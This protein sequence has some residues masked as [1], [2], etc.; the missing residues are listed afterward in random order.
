MAMAVILLEQDYKLTFW[1]IDKKVVDGISGAAANPRNFPE[2]IM[3]KHTRALPEIGEAVFGADLVVFSVASP[4]LRQTALSARLALSRNVAIVTVAKGLEQNSLKTMVEV[5]EESL[6]G[7]YHDHIAAFSGP[8]LAAEVV[9]KKPLAAVIASRRD[10]SY[11]QRAIRAFS[12]NWCKIY[13]TRDVLGVE[14]AGVAKHL[15]AMVSGIAQGLGW[16]ENSRA[17]IL[18]EAFRDAGRLVWK[19]GGTQETVYGLAGLGD[20]FASA[21]SPLGRNRQFGELLGQ[22]NTVAKAQASAG[23]TVEGITAVDCLHKLA[24]REKLRLPVLQA[25][26]DAVVGKEKAGKVFEELLKNL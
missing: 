20:T 13:E 17:W 24:L 9:Q 18:S 19:L 22:G 3:P 7:N 1:D 25:A 12:N 14:I 6:G 23:D 15:T 2:I 10:N 4:Y 21:F 11:S 5:L 26:Y 8:T 16:G